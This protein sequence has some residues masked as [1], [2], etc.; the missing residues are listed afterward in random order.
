MPF[1]RQARCLIE[2][3]PAAPGV[4]REAWPA[5]SSHWAA[6]RA[7]CSAAFDSV[8]VDPMLVQPEPKRRE[9]LKTHRNVPPSSAPLASCFATAIASHGNLNEN[10]SNQKGRRDVIII[11]IPEVRK[12]CGSPPRSR[13][14]HRRPCERSTTAFARRAPK[15]SFV[16]SPTDAPRPQPQLAES[17]RWT[18][19]A[20]SHFLT[21]A[22]QQTAYR[23]QLRHVEQCGHGLAFQLRA[24]S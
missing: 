4:A 13:A 21:D 8:A 11:S 5:V 23:N 24:S 7:G 6:S 20:M 12:G 14:A 15:Q 10:A 18:N 3:A 1:W 2:R 16:P 22:L 9:R 17:R 19:D